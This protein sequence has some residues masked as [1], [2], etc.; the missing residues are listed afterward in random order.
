[1]VKVNYECDWYVYI[2][3]CKDVTYYTGIATDVARRVNEHN[4]AKK[5]R[6]TR[7][8]KPVRLMYK[9]K[10][11][12]YNMARKREKEIKNYA[13][14]KKEELISRVKTSRP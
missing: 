4:N 10:C 11:A 13:R 9:D 1:V 7:Y 14:V 8:R 2:I 3:K 5:C 6:Y 12:N